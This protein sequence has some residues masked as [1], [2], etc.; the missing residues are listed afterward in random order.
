MRSIMERTGHLAGRQTLTE[1]SADSQWG[2]EARGG[3]V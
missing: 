2:A 1:V 3:L